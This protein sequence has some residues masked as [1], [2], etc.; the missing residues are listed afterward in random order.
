MAPETAEA[1]MTD[2]SWIV[3]VLSSDCCQ[4]TIDMNTV[5]RKLKLSHHTRKVKY[6]SEPQ[7]Y[8]DHP[9]RFDRAQLLCRDG[10]VGRGYWEVEWTGEVYIA[11]SY[12]GIRRKGDSN[13]TLFG[14]NNQSWSLYCS[15]TY[16]VWHD[17]KETALSSR[18][19]SSSSLSDSSRAAVYV[20]CHAGTLS[21]LKVSSDTL[22]HLHTFKTKFTEPVYAGF[23]VFTESSLRLC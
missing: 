14:W 19:Y 15:D 16:A 3:F 9:D 18:S 1:W 4:L 7:R 10:L 23:R 2:C 13:E 22:T 5:N 11:V 6:L 17:G 8:P 20:D 21:F 12:R